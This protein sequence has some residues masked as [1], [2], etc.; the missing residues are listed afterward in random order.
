MQIK[1]LGATE[2]EDQ[3]VEIPDGVAEVEVEVTTE[4]KAAP[5]SPWP[6]IAFFIALM[7][8]SLLLVWIFRG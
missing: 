3:I 6:S 4:Q 1:F 8:W 5:R 7:V 2:E